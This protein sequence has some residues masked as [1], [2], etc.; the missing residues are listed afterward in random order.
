VGA[1]VV[2]CQ[3]LS[4]LNLGVECAARQTHP[5]VIRRE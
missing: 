4:E 2:R 1:F 3:P 5:I